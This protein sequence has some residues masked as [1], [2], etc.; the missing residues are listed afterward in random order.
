[1]ALAWN[2]GTWGSGPFGEGGESVNVVL[3]GE[4]ALGAI[5]DGVAVDAGSNHGVVGEAAT[6]NIGSVTVS[7]SVGTT[8]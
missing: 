1:M 3:T 2:E 6:I 8:S 4:A 7:T 5:G